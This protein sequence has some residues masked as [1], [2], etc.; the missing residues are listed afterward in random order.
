[1]DKKNKRIDMNINKVPKKTTEEAVAWIN[2]PEG[3]K[4][5]KE[6]RAKTEAAIKEMKQGMISPFSIE[7][8]LD[9]IAREL[10]SIRE[11]LSKLEEHIDKQ[12]PLG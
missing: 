8:K 11:R 6:A 9:R 4:A 7:G 10:Q 2:S 5:L 3:V 12:Q 1:M